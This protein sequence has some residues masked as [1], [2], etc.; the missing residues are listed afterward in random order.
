MIPAKWAHDIALKALPFYSLRYSSQIPRWNSFEW[1]G[2][3]FSNPVGIAG[4]VDKNAENLEAWWRLGCGFVEVG[5]ITP[6]PQNANPGKIMD[7]RSEFQTLWNKMGF[8]SL[9][10]QVVLNNLSKIKNRPTPVFINIGKNRHTE[11]SNAVQ[12]YLK[13]IQTFQNQADAFVVNISS[14]N[15]KNL[16]ELQ[17]SHELKKLL[18]PLIEAAQSKPVLIKLSPDLSL[19][20]FRETLLTSIE[21]GISGF[22]LTNTTLHRKP[23]WGLPSEGGVSGKP[24]QEQS[25]QA[26]RWC[27]EILGEKRKDFL[28]ISV[29]GILTTEDIFERL[30]M[31]ADLVQIYSGLV[32]NGPSLLRQTAGVVSERGKQN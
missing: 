30:Q 20:N 2:I 24:L 16:R 11:N 21:C 23:E 8:P 22:V 5:T 26:L 18:I 4:G 13:L 25:K 29:G 1:R 31:G 32:F 15:T 28:I 3:F 17:Q 12:D 27:L 14:P 7:R 10:A 19:E 9:G 6:E